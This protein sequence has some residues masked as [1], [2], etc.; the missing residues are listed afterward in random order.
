MHAKYSEEIFT[1]PTCFKLFSDLS[2]ERSPKD[3]IPFEAKQYG[4]EDFKSFS[5]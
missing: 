3:Y 2:K 4:F 1:Y 5:N